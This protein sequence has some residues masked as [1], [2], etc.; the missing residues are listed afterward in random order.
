VDPGLDQNQTEL[1]VLVLAVALQVLAD[2]D[3]LLDHVVQI[4]GNVGLQTHRLH[5]AQDLVS[6]DETHLGN[7]VR[8]TQDDACKNRIPD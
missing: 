2:G 6:V 7:S 5:D 3:G 8:V 4:L 1:A